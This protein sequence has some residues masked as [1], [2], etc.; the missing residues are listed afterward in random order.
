M[1]PMFYFHQITDNSIILINNLDIIHGGMLK[2]IKMEII[3]HNIHSQDGNTDF[4]LLFYSMDGGMK[5]VMRV[6]LHYRIG[7]VQTQVIN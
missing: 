2:L 6:D 5:E 1:T 3:I 4:R 7:I